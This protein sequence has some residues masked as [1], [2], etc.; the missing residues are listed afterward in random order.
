MFG[1]Q[2]ICLSA[3]NWTFLA[4]HS[5]HHLLPILK[6]HDETQ[7][8]I[9]SRI[10]GPCYTQWEGHQ[11]SLWWHEDICLGSQG[12]QQVLCCTVLYVP[13]HFERK[14]AEQIVSMPYWI[15]NIQQSF[16][17]IFEQKL[18][19]ICRVTDWRMPERPTLPTANSF[20]TWAVLDLDMKKNTEHRLT[21][22]SDQCFWCVGR[23]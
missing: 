19:F 23:F 16:T 22:D 1:F 3:W 5:L 14:Q 4:L 7:S 20:Q 8:W 17:L 11:I 2:T 21:S 13:L 6:S 10:S 9:P 12:H 18:S 15:L